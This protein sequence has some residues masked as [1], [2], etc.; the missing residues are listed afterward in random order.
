MVSLFDLIDKELDREIF[1]MID[2]DAPGFT[3]QA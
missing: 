3:D 1:S 2:A